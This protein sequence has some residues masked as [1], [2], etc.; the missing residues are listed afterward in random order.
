MNITKPS[1]LFGNILNI[2][3]PIAVQ[4]LQFFPRTYRAFLP[5]SYSMNS[6]RP[7]L[8]LGLL[9]AFGFLLSSCEKQEPENAALD[10]FQLPTKDFSPTARNGKL[11]DAQPLPE[12]YN[13]M[14]LDQLGM[15][16]ITEEISLALQH[17][18]RVLEK[19]GFKDGQSLGNL[20]LTYA[21]MKEVIELLLE[22]KGS[23]P[24]DL[25]H[26][27]E[28]QQVRG[29]D[30]KGNVFFTGYYT[31]VLKVRKNPNSIYKY[32]IYAY[33]KNW[34]GHLPSRAD[35]DGEG[36]LNGLGLELAYAANAVDVYV[37]QLQGSGYVEYLETG[38][39]FLFR[40]AG[41]NGRRY[42]NIQRFLKERKYLGVADLSFSNIRKYLNEHPEMQDS[43][44]FSDRSYTFFTPQKGLVKGA[45]DVPLMKMISIAADPDYFPAGSVLLAAMPV[46]D[47]DEVIHHEYTLLLPQDVG[48]AIR[49]TGHVD[50]YCGVGNAGKK[51]SSVL[52]QY[53]R[54]WMLT[55]KKNQQVAEVF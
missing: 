32:P 3:I 17:Q 31:P 38:E 20:E 41:D 40:Y 29:R 45:A 12:V 44:L 52:H 35:I 51:R 24:D 53:G 30:K 37:M 10:T 4:S 28:A 49:G 6:F 34:E 1:N 7:V 43:V 36:H 27:L 23:Q 42:R 21:E 15:P 55:P 8:M 33:P 54:L 48:G 16:E 5:K 19:G 9:A 14:P 18:L 2:I 22:R 46:V 25:H 11:M 47:N 50:V 13:P 39:R 26:Y